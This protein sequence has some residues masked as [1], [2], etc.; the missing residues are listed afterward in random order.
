MHQITFRNEEIQHEK[1]D[2]RSYCTNIYIYINRIKLNNVGCT[3]LLVMTEIFPFPPPWANPA[4]SE[5]CR[6]IILL[7]DISQVW[8]VLD[9][10]MVIPWVLLLRRNSLWYLSDWEQSTT[11]L[12]QIRRCL[13]QSDWRPVRSRAS[14][15]DLYFAPGM[16]RQTRFCTLSYFFC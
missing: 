9:S 4:Y 11:N 13:S 16:I 8:K 7:Y 5:D 3:R 6:D 10:L 1:L 15:L 2:W 12:I 14:V